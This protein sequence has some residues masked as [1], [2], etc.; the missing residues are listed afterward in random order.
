MSSKRK[1]A[2]PLRGTLRGL[3]AS[4]A[5]MLSVIVG[6]A[7]CRRAPMLKLGRV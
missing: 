6:T 2:S 1:G 4:V 5:W 7:R 3:G